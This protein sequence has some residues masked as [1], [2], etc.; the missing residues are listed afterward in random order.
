MLKNESIELNSTL[1]SV[2]RT[3][4]AIG[5]ILIIIFSLVAIYNV[6]S[7]VS[8]FASSDNIINDIFSFFGVVRNDEGAFF[9]FSSIEGVM[10]LEL[11]TFA[12]IMLGVFF[13]GSLISPFAS[14]IKTLLKVGAELAQDCLRL[15]SVNIGSKGT[16][17]ESSYSNRVRGAEGRRVHSSRN[18][19]TDEL[20]QN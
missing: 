12:S 7:W 16:T 13:I 6:F 5:S 14:L 10:T 8:G 11:N 18:K 19:A 4:M 2:M 20:S 9:K 1:N 17:N 15:P 3:T